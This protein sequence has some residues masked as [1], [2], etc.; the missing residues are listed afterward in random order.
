[1][2]TK[3]VKDMKVK[4][5]DG[6]TEAIPLGVDSNYAIYA[7][8]TTGLNAENAQA[9]ISELKAIND[10]LQTYLLYDYYARETD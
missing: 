9:A 10:N 3:I 5:S 7:P 8:G 4:K 1:M 2:A 6:T